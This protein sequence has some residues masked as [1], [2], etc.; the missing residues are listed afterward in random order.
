MLISPLFG[1]KLIHTLWNIFEICSANIDLFLASPPLCGLAITHVCALL[2]S[3]FVLEEEEDSL[4]VFC[5]YA[6]NDL[7]VHFNGP[8]M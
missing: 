1:L 6:T 7:V 3:Y 2:P 5:T 4:E 8:I